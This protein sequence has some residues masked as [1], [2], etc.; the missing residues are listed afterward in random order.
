MPYSIKLCLRL[1]VSLGALVMQTE[2]KAEE[3]GLGGVS[4]PHFHSV[5]PSLSTWRV[6]D[7]RH[8]ITFPERK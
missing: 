3:A 7:G 5:Y 1:G 8:L 2:S 6:A 4:S